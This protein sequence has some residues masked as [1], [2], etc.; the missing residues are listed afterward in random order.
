MIKIFFNAGCAVKPSSNIRRNADSMKAIEAVCAK[1]IAA[2]PTMITQADFKVSVPGFKLTGVLNAQDT[3][4]KVEAIEVVEGKK[5][6]DQSG[7][8]SNAG[9]TT[10]K[11]A[12]KKA[13]KKGASK[14]RT[15][16]K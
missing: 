7:R 3:T 14:A 12:V 11:K 16:S 15:S 5:S 13:A 1:H 6:D 4:Y 9:T 2:N 8:S 10:V